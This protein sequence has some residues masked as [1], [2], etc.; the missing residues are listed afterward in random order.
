M[1]NKKVVVLKS[2]V[3]IFVRFYLI[4]IEDINN[5]KFS[6]KNDVP[7]PKTLDLGKSKDES[8]K[9]YIIPKYKHER[10][11]ENCSLRPFPKI[12]KKYNKT[13]LFIIQI[14]EL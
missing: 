6:P 8:K 12:P 7:L 11:L 1:N 4:K 5:I 9:D 14:M 13:S 10:L 2:S 3:E